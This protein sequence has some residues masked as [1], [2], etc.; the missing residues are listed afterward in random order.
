ML[1]AYNPR[2]KSFRQSRLLFVR[3]AHYGGE[4][5]ENHENNIIGI[6]H[7]YAG[8]GNRLVAITE[9]NDPYKVTPT[10]N[11]ANGAVNNYRWLIGEN[12][13]NIYYHQILNGIGGQ[14]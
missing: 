9:C 11:N 5:Y 2:I 3:K 1:G 12:Y 6:D 10:I 4:G 13:K 7:G 14:D 8:D